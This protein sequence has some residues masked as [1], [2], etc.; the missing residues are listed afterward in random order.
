MAGFNLDG[1]NKD[2]NMIATKTEEAEKLYSGNPDNSLVKRY[3]FQASSTPKGIRCT[4]KKCGKQ[5][6]KQSNLNEHE[7][8]FHEGI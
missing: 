7:R 2:V 8:S 1:S 3:K 4:C 5:M 6:T